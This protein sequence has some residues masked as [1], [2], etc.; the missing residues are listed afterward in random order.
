MMHTTENE[1]MIPE[2]KNLPLKKLINPQELLH[3]VRSAFSIPQDVKLEC[4]KISHIRYSPK[5]SYI[6]SFLVKS[7]ESQELQRYYIRCMNNEIF[8]KVAKD[9]VGL[10]DSKNNYALFMD[11]NILVCKF[12]F[13]EKLNLT[14]LTDDE[15]VSIKKVIRYKPE[16]RYVVNCNSLTYASHTYKNVIARIELSEKVKD[17]FEGTL[18]VIRSMDKTNSFDVPPIL[19]YSKKD[20][21]LIQEIVPGVSFAEK[22][23]D[24]DTSEMNLVV[25]ALSELHTLKIN[26]LIDKDAAS[27]LNQFERSCKI[28]SCGNDEIKIKLEQIRTCLKR[29]LTEMENSQPVVIHGDFHQG[30]ILLGESKT[31]LIDLDS[32]AIGSPVA[33][34]GSFYAQLKKMELKSLISSSEDIFNQ[35]LDSYRKNNNIEIDMNELKFYTG[36]A[37]VGLA[38][39]EL[40]RLRKNWYLKVMKLLYESLKILK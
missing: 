23:L 33:D 29:K 14:P 7:D 1:L 30:Q 16:T 35:F 37:L 22:L 26:G 2:D 39:K 34:L 40:R 31:W 18:R 25:K 36:C 27:Y 10:K 17:S 28:L 19:H 21:L 11:S 32:V 8:L 24:L 12:P 4:S 15:A 13:D 38:T 6:V 5:K 20:S 3:L 9:I